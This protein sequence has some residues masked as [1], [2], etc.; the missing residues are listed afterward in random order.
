MYNIN[1]LFIEI[2]EGNNDTVLK[3]LE[4]LGI[5]AVD[6]FNRTAL[7][8]AAFSNNIE[9]VKRLIEQEAKLDMQDKIGFSAL[10]FTAQEAHTDVTKLLLEHGANPNLVDRDG[11]TPA[12]VAIANWKAGKNMETLKLLVKHK[13]DLTI[14]NKAGRCALDLIPPAIKQQLEIA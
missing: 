5:N 9:L 3:I 4:E 1:N 2:K 14:K 13:C 11:N 10:H 6:N 12:W 8:N 7:T